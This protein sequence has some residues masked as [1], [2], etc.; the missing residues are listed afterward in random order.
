MS[1]AHA[2]SATGPTGLFLVILAP[3]PTAQFSYQ[4]PTLFARQQV[5]L[6][7]INKEKTWSWEK[8]KK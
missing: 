6:G 7:K 2:K 5:S 1:A 4:E 8:Q 3:L